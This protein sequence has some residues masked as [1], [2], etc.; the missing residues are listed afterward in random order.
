[1]FCI[2]FRNNFYIPNLFPTTYP[3]L[4]ERISCSYNRAP[5]ILLSNL[6]SVC[7][8]LGKVSWGNCFLSQDLTWCY[9]IFFNLAESQLLNPLQ[10]TLV[11]TWILSIYRIP[12]QWVNMNHERRALGLSPALLPLPSSC[13]YTR[14]VYYQVP[15][16]MKI[17]NAQGNHWNVRFYIN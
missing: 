5:Y 15:W 14:G 10:F 12:R 8:G 3:L 1:M 17:V 2:V 6:E 11:H 9:Q 16:T 13:P 4:G 7:H